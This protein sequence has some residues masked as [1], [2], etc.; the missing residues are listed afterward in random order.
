M[1]RP[2]P[3][4]AFTRED[5]YAA[6]R[7][8]VELASTLIPDAYTEQSFFDLE[9][10][11]VFAGSW[12]PVGVAGEL[13][14]PGDFVVVEV[15]GRSLIVCRNADG[16]LKAHHNVCRHRGSRLCDAGPGHVDRFFKCPYH[17]WAYDLNGKCLGT[18]L[19]TPDSE[20][21]GGSARDL[22]HERGQG[23]RQGGLRSPPGALRAV[24]LPDL[25]VP[26]RRGT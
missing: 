4:E 24:G 12:V 9:R 16:E 11:Q 25:R 18:P 14:K 23:V 1:K 22:R 8:P 7:L 10:E 26:R 21:P 19:F 13:P 15:A 5:T 6:T 17:S 3:A 2:L 20:V